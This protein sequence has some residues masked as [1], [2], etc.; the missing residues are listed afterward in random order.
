METDK[1]IKDYYKA[2]KI[3][4]EAMRIARGKC[5][6][7]D[8][9]D[10]Y[11]KENKFAENILPIFTDSEKLK[12]LSQKPDESK[13]LESARRLTERVMKRRNQRRRLTIVSSALAATAAIFAISFFL[14]YQEK[15]STQF[16]AA[17]KVDV[18]T[19]ILDEGGEVNLVQGGEIQ[20]IGCT[21]DK[22]QKNTI[23]YNSD[24]KKPVEEKIQY[25]TIIVPSKYTYNIILEDGTEVFL[26]ANSKLRYPVIFGLKEREVQLEGEACFK[27]KKSSR[28][29]IVKSNGV[30]VQVYG[31]EFN[32]RA[33]RD[34]STETVLVSGSVKVTNGKGEKI[35]LK[36]NQKCLADN[37]T[38]ELVVSDVEAGDYI[39]WREGKFKYVDQP[40]SR[41]LADLEAWY[42]VELRARDSVKAMLITLNMNKTEKFEDIMRFF[43]SVIDCKIINDGKGVYMVE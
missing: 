37:S 34:Q 28:P 39:Y 38:N 40:L 12:E 30:D 21:I 8:T 10:S 31:T 26:N 20:E 32:V 5:D 29:F 33:Y 6:D 27:V 9:I 18:P 15:D 16:I 41:V 25:N 7:T 14:F 1:D 11:L 35:M 2:K 23:S 13:K 22:S 42:G 19:L 17:K 24:S 3:A 4:E 36:P 43:E